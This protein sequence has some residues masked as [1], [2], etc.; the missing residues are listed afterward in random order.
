VVPKSPE[1]NHLDCGQGCTIRGDW[2]KSPRS[3][4]ISRRAA[5]KKKKNFPSSL[6]CIFGSREWMD[7]ATPRLESRLPFSKRSPLPMLGSPRV[8]NSGLE[9]SRPRVGRARTY[10]SRHEQ[11]CTWSQG[12]KGMG[13]NALSSCKCSAPS[14]VVC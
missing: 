10:A 7:R 9:R 8:D 14:I 3:C 4:R 5:K 2:A 13:V 1:K 6:W 12:R 11:I